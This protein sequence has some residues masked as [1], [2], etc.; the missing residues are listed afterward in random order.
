MTTIEDIPDD[1]LLDEDGV[2]E[3][4]RATLLG[5]D[6]ELAASATKAILN[7]ARKPEEQ[8]GLWTAK[9]LPKAGTGPE[10]GFPRVG[11]RA[12]VLRMLK[13]VLEVGDLTPKQRTLVRSAI[14]YHEGQ[15]ASG[16]DERGAQLTQ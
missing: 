12:L 2:I 14:R 1:T 5:E 9:A 10:D 6:R 7:G 16:D 15:Q 11:A 4:M 8:V 3:L 13:L